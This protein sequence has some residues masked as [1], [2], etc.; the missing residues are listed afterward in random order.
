VAGLISL[1]AWA[2]NWHVSQIATPHF[3]SPLDQI[4]LSTL[5]DTILPST[6]TLGARALGVHNFIDKIVADCLS[7]SE[8]ERMT[9]GLV[10]LDELANKKY[11]NPFTSCSQD[12]RII[13]LKAMEGNDDQLAFVK[14]AKEMTI[15]G[16]MQSEYYLTNI[17]KYEFIPA[18]FH[19]CV[20]VSK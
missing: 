2:T 17:A 16:Y 8:Q 11:G 3:F 14:M 1:P 13:I 10:L 18:R 5:V 4:T 20:P 19:G 15:R 7:I 9:N 6:N 12:Q